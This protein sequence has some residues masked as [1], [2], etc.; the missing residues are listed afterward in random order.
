MSPFLDVRMKG[1]AGRASIEA[2]LTLID[3]RTQVLPAEQIAITSAAGRV[4][5]EPVHARVDVPSF[6]R[7][8]MDGYALRAADTRDSPVSLIV[9]GEARP[10]HPFSGK[11]ERGQTVR[12]MTGAPVPVGADAILV[13]EAAEEREG[14]LLVQSPVPAKKHIICIGEDVSKGSEILSS[15]R[16]LRP[17]DVGLAVAVGVASVAVVRR[18]RVALLVTGDELLPA[19]ATPQDGRIFD[20]NSPMLAALIERDGGACQPVRY[21]PDDAGALRAALRSTDADVVLIT[22]GSSV[23]TEDHAPSIVAEL[24]ELAVHGVALRPAGPLGVGFIAG[25][26]VFL[27]PGNP[28]SCL[29]A[30]DLFAGRAVRR[31]GG[32]NAAIAYRQRT[33]PLAEAV[34]SAPGRT[35]YVRVRVKPEGVVPVASRGA[36]SLSSAVLA[37]GFILVEANRDSLEPGETVEVFF[38]DADAG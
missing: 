18:P 32:R 23:G 11:V 2:V 20:S 13:A 5:A 22:G 4:L 36:S 25:R 26:I 3:A 19:G 9:L 29:C 30:Y 7:S 17:Q 35:D 33:L 37:D 12:I 27:I 6:D 10:A 24:G 31:L 21:L 8:A 38:Y 1:F 15:G 34:A 16:C 28:V 14:Q